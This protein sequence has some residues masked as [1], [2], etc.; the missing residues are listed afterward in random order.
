MRIRSFVL[1]CFF[2]IL[3][4]TSLFA[5]VLPEKAY[6]NPVVILKIA[7]VR[8]NKGC[9]D[10]TKQAGKPLSKEECLTLLAR[11]NRHVWVDIRNPM[12][13]MI[14]EPVI[15]PGE[16]FLYVKTPKGQGWVFHPL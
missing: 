3:G 15:Y 13:Q 5:Q 11:H 9:T 12:M 1:L 16:V 6:V 10:A 4:S 7:P 2:S 8:K 14:M